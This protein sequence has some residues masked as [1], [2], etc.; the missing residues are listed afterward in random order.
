M[1]PKLTRRR[2][3]HIRPTGMIGR[4]SLPRLLQPQPQ[5]ATAQP[6][7][8]Q[9]R[10]F[11]FLAGVPSQLDMPD[12]MAGGGPGFYGSNYA[13]FVIESNPSQPDFEVRDLRAVDGVSPARQD[14]RRRLLAEAERLHGGPG[15]GRPE[16]METYYKKAYDLV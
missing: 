4:L 13:P 7:N 11:P 10:I 15:K 8:A 6:A 16:A 1:R 12:M 9:A 2:A 3:L 5:A 14:R